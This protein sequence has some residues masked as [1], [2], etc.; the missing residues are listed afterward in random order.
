MSSFLQN[1]AL[2]CLPLGDVGKPKRLLN[3]WQRG[4]PPF[5]LPLIGNVVYS[6]NVNL[7]P[8]KVLCTFSISGATT[9][10]LPAAVAPRA[11]RREL[12]PPLS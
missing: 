8:E 6:T 11:R 7:G 9:K 10:E 5:C 4:I 12:G 1:A 3:A 2:L